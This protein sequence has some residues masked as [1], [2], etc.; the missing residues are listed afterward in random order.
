MFNKKLLATLLVGCLG[1]GV[2]P[3]E[4]SDSVTVFFKAKVVGTACFLNVA[5]GEKENV[6]SGLQATTVDFGNVRDRYDESDDVFKPV[7]FLLTN[8]GEGVYGAKVTPGAVTGGTPNGHIIKVDGAANNAGSANIA[9]YQNK[10]SASLT[11]FTIAGTTVDTLVWQKNGQTPIEEVKH[12][13]YVRLEKPSENAA[14][15]GPVEASII[16][17]ATYH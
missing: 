10:D 7:T 9:F 3:A 8:C 1:L 14:E 15:L 16:F 2:A 6:T 12:T 11:P 4:A 5:Q 17:N 13:I